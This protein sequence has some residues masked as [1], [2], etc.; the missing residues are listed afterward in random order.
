VA[1]EGVTRFDARGQTKVA[2]QEVSFTIRHL[3]DKGESV[4]I[5]GP[6]GCGKSTLLRI[7]AGAGNARLSADPRRGAHWKPI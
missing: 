2:L 6:S 5:V 4:A 1:F 3:P 7:I